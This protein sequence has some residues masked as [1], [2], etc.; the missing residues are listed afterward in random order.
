LQRAASALDRLHVRLRPRIAVALLSCSAAA[1][2]VSASRVARADPQADLEKAHNAYVAHRYEDAETRLR[3]LLDPQAG[4]LKDSDSVA[5]ARMYLGAVLLAENKKDEAAKTFE[6]LVRDKPD[7]QAD[8]LRVSLDAID[9]LTDAKARLRDELAARQAEKIKKEVEEKA[10]LDTE[11]KNAALRLAKLEEL[12]RTELVTERNSRWIGLLPFGVGQFQ[13]GDKGLGW[14]FFSSEVLL[15]A[16]SAVGAGVALY[17]QQQAVDA[18]QRSDG[19]A[20]GWHERAVQAAVTGD[21]LAGGF[22]AMALIGVVHA[23]LSFVPE[24]VTVRRHELPP[25]SLSPVVG[26]G[27]VGLHGTF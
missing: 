25:L 2:V 18:L 5:D 23:Q 9:A 14:L 10:K 11:R 22:L 15:A 4:E 27:G 1:L 19:T 21:V 20:E 3:A 8:P 12:A 24:R 17:D 7:Y 13:N 26:P 6:T 16:G